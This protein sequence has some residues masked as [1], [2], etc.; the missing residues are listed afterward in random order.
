MTEGMLRHAAW[1]ARALGRAELS[2]FSEGDLAELAASIGV[3]RVSAGTRLMAQGEPVTFIGLIEEGEVELYHRS[4]IR[5]VMIQILRS[6]DT[7][8]DIP[9]FCRKDAPFSARALTDVVLIQMDEPVLDRL[10]HTRPA[11]CRRF[12]FSL[13]ARLERTQLRLLQLTRGDLRSQLATLLLDES[14]GRQGTIRLPQSTLAELLGATRPS[15]NR[16]L[17]AFEADGLIDLEY[18]QVKVIDPEGLRALASA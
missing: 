13:A 18:R 12:L 16:V 11:L 9:Y 6:G 4:G 15:V 1:M 5:R 10:I 8:G 7:M 2:L 3:R 14:E 17:K